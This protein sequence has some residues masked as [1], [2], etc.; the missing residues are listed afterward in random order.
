MAEEE[1]GSEEGG[2]ED[3]EGDEEV[4]GKNIKKKG[5]KREQEA[6]YDFM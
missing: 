5:V 2:E 3:Y 4:T 6:E 1:Y